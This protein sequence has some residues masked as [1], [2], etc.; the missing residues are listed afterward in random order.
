MKKHFY[1]PLST[2]PAHF[3]LRHYSVFAIWLASSFLSVHAQITISEDFDYGNTSGNLSGQAG[4]TGFAAAWTGGTGAYTATGLTFGGLS[5]AGG[6]ML[7]SSG[8]N[9]AIRQITTGFAAS[10]PVSGSFLFKMNAAPNS[11]SVLMLG[12]GTAGSSNNQNH[13]LGFMP[14]NDGQSGLPALGIKGTSISAMTGGGALT[15]G[16]T[17]LYAFSYDNGSTS[18]WILTLAQYNN[19]YNGTTL[20]QAAM[21]ATTIGSGATNVT[22]KVTLSTNPANLATMDYLYSYFFSNGSMTVDRIRMSGTAALGG[23]GST[24]TTYT[25][26]GTTNTDWATAS[27]WTGGVVPTTALLASGDAVVIAAN[28]IMTGIS[29]TLPSGTS[30]TVNNGFSLN[31]GTGSGI[32]IASGVTFTLNASASLIQGVITN[33]G[34]MD[35]YGSYTAYYMTN[36]SGG[37]M[38]VK[39]GGS[40]SCPACAET[41]N[42]GS[43]I[44]NDGTM[45]LGTASSWQCTVNNNASGTITDGGNGAQIQLGSSSVVINAGSFV[46]RTAGT[47]GS[48][49]NSGTLSTPSTCN[50]TIKT[51]ATFSNSGN[52]T[53]SSSNNNLNIQ[54]S[55]T[56]TNNSTGIITNNG[57]MAVNAT[58]TF[59]NNGTYKGSGAYNT[60]LFTNPSGGI[61]APGTSPGCQTYSNG[62]TNAGTLQIELGGTTACTGYDR[63]NVTGTATL[64][65]TLDVSLTSGYTGNNGDLLTIINATTLSGTFATVN[66]PANWF[67]NYNLPAVGQVTLSYNAPLTAAAALNFDGVDDYVVTSTSPV[68]TGGGF[69]VELWAKRS[70]S[71]TYDIAVGQGSGGVGVGNVLHVGFRN[72]NQFTFAFSYDDLDVNASYSD[73][74]WHHWA[75]VYTSAPAGSN[76][77]FVYRDGV[78]VGSRTTNGAY[79]GSGPLTI[80]TVYYALTGDAFSGTIDEVRIWN[81]ARSCE[82][83]RQ[84]RNCELT[85][86]EP[87]LVAYYKFNQGVAEGTNTGVTTLIDATANGNNGTFNNMPRT[88]STSNFVTPGGVTTGTSCPAVTFP[89]INLK[90]NGNDI[91]YGSTTPAISNHTDFG[92]VLVNGSFA[93]TFTIDNSAGTADLTISSITKSGTNQSEFVVSGITLPMTVTAGTTTTFTVTFT[94]TA[95]GTRTAT[96]T[97]NNNDCDEVAYDFAITGNGA[98]AGAALDFDGIN[99]DVM[100]PH[101]SNIT[102]DLNQD[103]TVSLHVKI[104]SSNQPNTGNIDNDIVEKVGSGGGYPYVIRYYNHTAGAGNNGK[105]IAARW[106]GSTAAIVTSTVTLNDDTWHHIAFVKSGPTLYLY[107]D[108][109]LNSTTPDLTT[110]STANTAPLYLGSR[111]GQMNWFKGGIDNLRIWNVARSCEE[112]RQLRNCELTGSEPNLVAYYKFNQG[113]AAS[114]NSTVTSL[115]DATAN[116]NNGTFNHFALNG[117]TSNFI[118]PGGVTSGTSC[119]AVVAPE[120]NLQGGSPLTDIADGSTTTS[121]T[122][123]TDFGSVLV[124][125][126]VTK[127]FTI[128]NATGSADLVISSITKSGTNQSEFVVSGITLPMTITAGTTTTFTVTFTPTASGTRTATLIVNNNDCDE[129]AYDFAVTGNGALAG[130]AL[131]FD[132]VDDFVTGTSPTSFWGTTPTTIEFWSKK[133]PGADMFVMDLGFTYQVRFSNGKLNLSGFFLGNFQ[134][135]TDVV[136]DNTW[137]HYAITYDGNGTNSSY[138]AYVNGQPV[139]FTGS[140]GSHPSTNGQ[141]RVGTANNN[142]FYTG[143]IDEVRIWKEERT[144]AQILANYNTEISSMSPCLDMYLK[145][146]QGFVGANNSTITTATDAANAVVTNGTLTNFV[147]TG[148]TSNWVAGSGITEVSS[149]YVPAPEANLKGIDNSTIADGTTTT[150]TTVGTN[151]GSI[152]V[153]N[154]ITHMFT[155]ENT[156]NA[157][158]TVSNITS[159][160]PQFTVSSIS[161]SPIAGNNFATFTITF[162]PTATGAQNATIIVINNDCD[163]ANYNFAVTGTGSCVAPT[164]ST[165]PTNQTAN[166]TMGA[167]TATV[168]YTATVTGTP[169]PTITYVFTGATTSSGNG[170]GSGA[171]FNKGI[172][173]VTL[174]ATNGCGG[175]ATCS[176]TVTVNDTEAPVLACPTTQTLTASPATCT[177]SYT[178]A[179]PISDNCTGATWGYTLTGAT[180]GAGS[181]IADGTGS[182]AISFNVGTTTVTLSGTDGTNAA[183]GCSFT[184]TVNAPEI[185]VQGN[186]MSIADGDATPGPDD[187]HT[188]FGSVIV[189]NNVVRTFTIENTGTAAL[190]IS[191]ITSSTSKFAISNVPTS[192][193]AMSSATFT[194][195]FVPTAPGTQNATITINNND[196]NEAVYDFAVTGSSTSN[197]NALHFDGADDYVPVPFNTSLMGSTPTTIEF[198]AK[199]PLQGIGFPVCINT[200]DVAVRFHSGTHLQLEHYGGPSFDMGE[201]NDGCWHHYAF[202]WNGTTVY[203]YVDG[204][205]TPKPKSDVGISCYIG[206]YT[207][208]RCL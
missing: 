109:V 198:W 26:N 141:L 137:T 203:G 13:Y 188:N 176:F 150:S 153:S 88:G 202:V 125:G 34:T 201:V 106:N 35:I 204:Q 122:N 66:L 192:V 5:G 180:T 102:F 61:V 120:I 114:D 107:V 30:M 67:I 85:G 179:D 199:A 57:T 115:T 7:V 164:F 112:I 206:W 51:G 70:G 81:T 58:G 86:S 208:H 197:P 129:A 75:C 92:G 53:F 160:N 101:S 29:L 82:E 91:N 55:A 33:A 69:T 157:D 108:G 41:M 172:T 3:L 174:T 139:S 118:T 62:F 74:N 133:A 72:T 78:L 27:N 155:F 25:F 193:A 156:G 130:A 4:G 98:L 144:A 24:T 63:L 21:N 1:F 134:T 166:T 117:S 113:L 43:T 187:D 171:T 89:E 99:D 186:S 111:L 45:H 90:G 191:G 32:S 93:R 183:T 87:N 79:G 190:T 11:Q 14:A 124:N 149:A 138:K 105:I 64:G 140:Y 77:Q 65:G 194:V 2:K 148:S 9:N 97:V 121:T 185:N 181:A 110:G 142:Y 68:L 145:F 207:F 126:S 167:C 54:A 103:F 39:S 80:G 49:T 28:C 123:T 60:S 178:I 165:C 18:A 36:N 40:Y 47:A 136:V 96:I 6:A 168:N 37:V 195:T 8:G 104:P 159:S 31:L 16:T 154:S 23:L 184:V 132:G 205:P 169:T 173:T 19:F 163:E 119:S 170:T 95:S 44:N 128:S 196:C 131:D 46:S 147:L 182:G 59:T 100:I 52:M 127:T 42:A 135:G 50:F 200:A 143:A 94:P 146:N 162:T 71:G 56:L 10:G 22:G 20:D 48:F 116:G 151:F 158:L 175:N 15:V 189:G 177:A 73:N 76:N 161:T 152:Q 84:L 12:L 38:N 83:I 17:Y